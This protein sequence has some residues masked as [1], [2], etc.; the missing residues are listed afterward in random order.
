MRGALSANIIRRHRSYYLPSMT[1][2]ATAVW[3][4]DAGVP[5]PAIVARHREHMGHQ[6]AGV[7]LLEGTYP[8]TL[9]QSVRTVRLNRYLSQMTDPT[10][11]R[12]FI[13]DPEGSYAAHGLTEEEKALLRARDWRGLIRY[14]VIFFG[15]EKFA[16]VLGIPNAAV[17]AG[18]RGQT[19]EEFQKTRNAPD[20]LYSVA[21]GKA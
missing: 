20:A 12:G 17:Y 6:L 14:G 7:E 3:D 11:R 2:I 1:G 15:L 16:A 8:F 5:S 21:G 4:N 18:M 9:A 13:T 19:L 10:H